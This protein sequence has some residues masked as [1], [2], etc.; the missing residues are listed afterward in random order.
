M[1]TIR[2]VIKE[3][4]PGSTY[5]WRKIYAFYKKHRSKNTK[6]IFTDKYLRN[7]WGSIES[8]S[9]YGSE[10]MQ[11]QKLLKE[12][13]LLLKKYDVKTILDIPCGD[14]NWMK[15]VD[16][17]FESYIGGDIVDELIES[18]KRNFYEYGSFRVLNVL[19]DKLPKADL[20]FCRDCLV[21]FS[22][23]DI[24]DALD[25]IRRSGAK[26]LLTTTYPRH[27]NRNILTGDWRQLNLMDHPFNLP[28]PIELLNEESSEPGAKGDK[29]LGLWEIK[30]IS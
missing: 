17:N 26:Y 28:S 9:G 1:T 7:G 21:H 25:N 23:D 11:T 29:S 5:V 13:P 8:K 4:I 20:I 3:S 19:K 22:Y 14:F 10:L 12:L 24:F 30:N 27:K 15:H 18:N 6:L 16:Y 2:R